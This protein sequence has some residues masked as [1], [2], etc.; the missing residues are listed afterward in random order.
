MRIRAVVLSL[1]L[2]LIVAQQVRPDDDPE[3]RGDRSL[4]GVWQMITRIQDGTPSDDDLIKNRTVT[5]DK[6]KY[7]IHDRQQ[8]TVQLSYKIDWSK[9][10]PTIDCTFV[11]PNGGGNDVGIIQIKGNTLYLCLAQGGARPDKF[12]SK[13]GDGRILATYK[14][15]K[16]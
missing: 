14:K 15:V 2:L 6:D 5:F 9:K 8:L 11:I 3:P 12:E 13:Q 16:K 10:P 1:A 7:S 4:N